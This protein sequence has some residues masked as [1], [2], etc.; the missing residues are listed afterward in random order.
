MKHTKHTSKTRVTGYRYEGSFKES[1]VEKI[2]EAA[3]KA[4]VV[5][6]FDTGRGNLVWFN[7]PPGPEMRKLRDQIKAIVNPP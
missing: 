4:G 5:T 2:L 6:E 7:G 1:D 3:Q